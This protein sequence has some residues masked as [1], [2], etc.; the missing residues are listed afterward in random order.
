MEDIR[1]SGASGGQER[2][3][4]LLLYAPNFKELPPVHLLNPSATIFGRDPPPGGCTIQQAA[5]SRVHARVSRG[6]EGWMIADLES[7]NGTFVN[8]RAIDEATIGT[9]DVVRIGDALFKLVEED[10]DA[11]LGYLI[12]GT[13]TAETSL[14]PRE[15]LVGGLKI[16]TMIAELERVAPTVLPILILGETG[17]GKELVAHALHDA[18]GRRGRF[19]AI[20]CAAIPPSLFESEL[21]GFKRGAFTGAL[22]DKP[23]LV[24]VA[25]GGTLFLDEIGDLPLEAQAKLLRMIE[26]REI[27]PLGAT[28]AEAVDVRIVCATHMDLGALVESG[29]FRSDLFARINGY[30]VQL[31]P[32]RERKEDLF[33]LVRHFLDQ[34]GR[35]DLQVGLPFMFALCRYDWP[36]NVRELEAAMKRAVAVADGSELQIAHLPPAVRDAA[37][38]KSKPSRSTLGR[39]TPRSPQPSEQE[40]RELLERF[41]GNIAAIAREL[42]RD[43]AQV[44]RWIKS[45]RI[46]VGGYRR[47]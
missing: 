40:L 15:T 20:N 38:S 23:G 24:Q 8:G 30:M 39:S 11:F 45:S 9:A 32:L 35:T 25:H 41:Q 27:I 14:A 47:S 3:G 22:S 42:G 44:H 31:P 2:A 1:G 46:D 36:H 26:A 6:E 17:T 18:S 34:H 33:M 19:C 21:F 29:A 37:D 7:R 4:F 5:V 28:S 10:A 13:T 12:D 43:R 16:R